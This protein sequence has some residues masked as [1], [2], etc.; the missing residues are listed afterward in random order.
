V[1][2]PGNFSPAPRP[3]RERASPAQKGPQARNYKYIVNVNDGTTALKPL[4]LPPLDPWVINDGQASDAKVPD[5]GQGKAKL[6]IGPAPVAVASESAS[7]RALVAAS[8]SPA[9][10]S[11]SAGRKAVCRGSADRTRRAAALRRR[12]G[13][14]APGRTEP[15]GREAGRD[16]RAPDLRSAGRSTR[17]PRQA[18]P[19]SAFGLRRRP[20]ES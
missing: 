18:P 13:K 16:S 5:S 3:R 15:G 4:P 12:E 6:G 7:A 8:R 10:C 1:I 11:A 9:R 19:R 17:G 20:R 2:D 14:Y